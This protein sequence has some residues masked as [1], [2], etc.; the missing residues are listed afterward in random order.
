G[1]VRRTRAAEVLDQNRPARGAVAL[2]Q[3]PT[4]HAVGGRQ[5]QSAVDV[6]QVETV[7][8]DPAV[9]THAGARVDVF[10]HGGAG[11]GAVTLPQ[12]H[13]VHVVGGREEEGAVH[14]C[15]VGGVRV[16]AP[17]VDVLDDR[18]A[19]QHAVAL[20][21]LVAVRAVVGLEEQGAVDVREVAGGR[22]DS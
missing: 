21:Q 5:E 17:R 2:P 10:D 1:Q 13:A 9:T 18:G 15:Q 22:T 3:R 14:V 6:G 19:G 16:G 12:L 7:V 20:P 4:V 11:G 8:I